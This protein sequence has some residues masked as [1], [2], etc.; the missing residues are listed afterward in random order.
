MRVLSEVAALDRSRKPCLTG[1]TLADVLWQPVKVLRELDTRRA[2]A[3]HLWGQCAA[4]AVLGSLFFGLSLV[5][6][7]PELD[8]TGSSLW[9]MASAGVAWIFFG[10]LL[11]IVT[12]LPWK[13]L[14]QACLVTMVFGELILVAGAVF[15]FVFG[16]MLKG[17]AVAMGSALAWVALSNGVMATMLALQLKGVG[18][19]VWQ[20]VVLWI[21]GLNGLGALFF[22][23]FR[24]LLR[25]VS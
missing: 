1:L 17:T 15:H 22:F 12:G 24:D 21:F 23:L 11:R 13:I 6:I 19:V 9:F 8:A 2:V 5:R 20:S 18:V 14:A 25:G 3:W 10:P 7:L 16:A 4:I